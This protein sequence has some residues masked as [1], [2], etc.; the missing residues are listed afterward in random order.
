MVVV[1]LNSAIIKPNVILEIEGV[2]EIFSIGDVYRKLR[3]DEGHFLDESKRLDSISEDLSA[4]K[5]IDV[6]ASA[7]SLSQQLFYDKGYVSSVQS[8]SLDI[9]DNDL[10][11]TKLL[12]PGIIVD[13]LLSR[14]AVVY[15]SYDGAA[16]PEESHPIIYGVIEGIDSGVGSVKLR[17]I[18]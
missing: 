2:S 11:L 9:I 3:L 10:L 16:H 18:S 17:V 1:A 14:K 13:D 5:L 8:L 7:L 15:L 4:Y 6:K 12:S